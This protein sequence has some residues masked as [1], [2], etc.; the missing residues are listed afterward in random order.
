MRNKPRKS[1]SCFRLLDLKKPVNAYLELTYECRNSCSGCPS[2]ISENHCKPMAGKEWIELISHFSIFLSEIRLTGGEPTLHPDFNDILKYLVKG[3]C[4]FRIYTNG[5][6][7]DNEKMLNILSNAKNFGGF[8][9]SLHGS[10]SS[11][12]EFFTGSCDYSKIISNIENTAKKSIPFQTA[13]IIGGFNSGNTAELIKRVTEL[14]SRRHYFQRYI[15]PVRNGVSINREDMLMQLS[16]IHRIP[17]YIYSYRIGS[18]FPFCYYKGAQRCLAGIADITITPTGNI[19]P[20]PFSDEILGKWDFKTNRLS[21][22]KKLKEWSRDFNEECLCCNDIAACMGGCRVM[23]R[24]FKF[25]RDPLMIK[26]AE[27]DNSYQSDETKKQI[28]LTGYLNLAGKVRKESFGYILI[29]EDKVIPVTDKAFAIIS[30][31]DGTRSFG[32]IID[33]SGKEAENFIVSL[34]IRGFLELV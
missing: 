23:R 26:A 27:D 7:P 17:S 24:N 22:S 13:S 34:Y 12:H 30:L 29:N 28:T 9:F 15:G 33:I 14:G 25:K 16:Y 21:K 31:C 19:K 6:W 4:S 2:R 3:Q 10:T 11:V 18:C 5:L 32:E 20:C 8:I 1:D